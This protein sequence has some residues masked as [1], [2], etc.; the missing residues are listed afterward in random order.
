MTTMVFL[1]AFAGS[2]PTVD[3]QSICRSARSAALPEDQPTAYAGCLREEQDARDQL[4][5]NW[6]KYSPDAHEACAEDP[7]FSFSYVELLTCLEMQ[8]GGS[9]SI[10]G[11][12]RGGRR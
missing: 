2:L 10:Q 5:R 11:L 7:A 1:L 6:T 9:L 3:M 4:R 8:P 12:G